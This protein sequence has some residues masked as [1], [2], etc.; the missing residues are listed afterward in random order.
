MLLIR[1]TLALSL[2]AATHANPS[3]QCGCAVNAP[4]GSFSGDE[5]TKEACGDCQ[6][7]ICPFAG[8]KRDGYC[9]E[10]GGTHK[11]CAKVSNSTLTW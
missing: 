11:I 9:H 1:A 10:P 7:A 6:G 3:A 4:T 5:S 2:L 8:V